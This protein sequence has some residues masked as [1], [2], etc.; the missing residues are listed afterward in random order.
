MPLAFHVRGIAVERDIKRQSL[1]HVETDSARRIPHL[2]RVTSAAAQLEAAE[3]IFVAGMQRIA[4]ESFSRLGNRRPPLGVVA[5]IAAIVDWEF[6][7]RFPNGQ[8]HGLYKR[9]IAKERIPHGVGGP[10]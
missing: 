8:R 10:L 4:A 2:T 3:A 9:R 5:D 7:A 1:A 6:D